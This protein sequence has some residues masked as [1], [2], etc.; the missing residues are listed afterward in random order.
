[1]AID[2]T[3]EVENC[4]IRKNYF[5]GEMVINV[6]TLCSP[7]AKDLPVAVVGLDQLLGQTD[8]I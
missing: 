4:L 2:M 7:L 8:F 6:N 3:I 5:F 1:M